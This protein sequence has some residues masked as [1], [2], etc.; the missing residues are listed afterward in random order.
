MAQKK[1][2][3]W[4]CQFDSRP[5]KVNNRLDFLACRWRDTYRWK[6]LNEGYNFAIDI[7]SIKGLQTK[8]WAFKVVGVPISGISRLQ[9]GNLRTKW[10]LGV[11]P[12]LGIENTKILGRG[13][14]CES[15]FACGLFVHQ[16]CSNYALTNLFGLCRSVWVIDCLSHF[17]VPIPKL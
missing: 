13:E 2:Q 4:C 15:V 9:L 17:L 6:A 14:S 10:H 11:G 3:E 7:S 12:W 16:K 5:L 8:L 1:G